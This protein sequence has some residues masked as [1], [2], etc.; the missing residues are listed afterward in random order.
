MGIT[1]VP[2]DT[3][4]PDRIMELG[5]GCDERRANAFGLLM[6]LNML[7]DRKSVV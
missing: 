5:T 2:L 6:S 7:I 3:P 4:V 1:D